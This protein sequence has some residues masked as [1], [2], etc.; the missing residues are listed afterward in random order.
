MIEKFWNY[1][2][3]DDLDPIL[4][5]IHVNRR[6]MSGIARQ[7]EENGATI[8]REEVDAIQVG[9]PYEAHGVTCYRI[10]LPNSQRIYLF[11]E[12]VPMSRIR[13]HDNDFEKHVFVF[14]GSVTLNGENMQMLDTRTIPKGDES[15]FFSP[16]GCQF[17]LACEE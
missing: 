3:G 2:K 13:R 11:C 16:N 17:L 1:L 8:T 6:I 12:M 9:M 5:D 7:L 14:S 4:D 15:W 10:A